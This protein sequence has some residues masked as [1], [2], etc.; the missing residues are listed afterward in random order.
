MSAED[1]LVVPEDASKR[2]VDY[3]RTLTVPGGPLAGWKIG[4][5][6]PD[7][8][9]PDL[10]V[11]VRIVDGDNPNVLLYRDNLQ[12]RVWH[13]SEY[14][15]QRYSNLVLAYVRRALGART[16]NQPIPLPDP[17]DPARTFY[18]SSALFPSVGKAPA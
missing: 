17:V 5:R 11:Q 9:T 6:T 8:E 13:R 14:V 12:F 3:L 16:T 1:L 18:Q 7:N 15:A 10:F 4:T 2:A